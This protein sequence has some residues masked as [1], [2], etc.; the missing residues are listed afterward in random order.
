MQ[1]IASLAFI[2][3]VYAVG[4]LVAAK[5]RG[6]VS[7]LFTCSVIFLA[8]FWLGAPKALFAVAQLQGIGAVLIGLILVHMGT[9]LNLAQLKAQWKTVLIALAA[10]IGVVVCLAAVGAPLIGRRAVLVSAPPIAGGIIAAIQMA[11]AARAAGDQTLAVL[12]TLLLVVQGF[13]GYPIASHCLKNEARRIRSALRRGEPAYA[14]P[15]CAEADP[16][17]TRQRPGGAAFHSETIYLAKTA[18]VALAAAFV[19]ASVNRWTGHNLLDRNIL[20]LLFGVLAAAAGLL[21]R[22]VLTKANSFGFGMV[23]L[24]AVIFANLS[25]AAPQVILTLLPTLA[26]TL[27]IGSAGIVFFSVAAGKCLKVSPHFAIAI[28]ISA[29]FGFPGTYIIS[30]EVARATGTSQ[31]EIQALADAILPPMLTAGF[32]TVSLASVVLAG[33]LAPLL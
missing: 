13:V 23:A 12:A 25:E 29:L 33:L 2:L 9:L 17:R 5:T 6:L 11:E 19:S 8:A 28:G 26:L 20:A 30:C 14:A 18:A 21:E 27:G 3:A 4:D 24:M 10:V 22:N 7:M 16:A 1:G 15:A 31:E 32:V